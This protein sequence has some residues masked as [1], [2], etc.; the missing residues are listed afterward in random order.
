MNKNFYLLVLALM[1]GATISKAQKN[2]FLTISHKLGNSNF[3]F[4]QTAQNN[5]QQNFRITRVDY[6]I[7]SIKIIHDGGIETAVPAHY[8]LAKGSAT[9]IDLL[10]NFNVTNVEG[11]KFSIGVEAPTN[12]SDITL[13]PPGHP[14]SFQ[15]PSMHWGWASGYRFLA[16]EGTTGLGF[17]T[18]FE[19]HGLG[20]ANYFQQT[21][22]AT[23]VNSGN[24]VYIN[25]DA[26]YAMALENI[27]VSSGPIDHGVNATDLTALE[28]F[29]DYVFS[30]GLSTP[31]SINN[32][33]KNL[34]IAV[35]P[36]PSTK[37]LF[38]S[39]D[40]QNNTADK[41]VMTDVAGKVLLET[42]LSTKNE[43]DISSTAK[44]MYVLK[45]YNQGSL[46]DSRKIIKE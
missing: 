36:N 14:L 5:L 28:N 12:N 11:V 1:F 18:I 23:G 21:V 17:T 27:N 29:R 37:T 32:P 38:I 22:M 19:M 3:A 24:D 35:Y 41:M 46:V 34:N 26:D 39:F 43:I 16:L 33:E 4:N 7:S 42:S 13:Q 45:F 30:P 25:L 15:S 8:I 10:G 40:K 2:V 6:Y 44:G 20:N 9:V 31:A